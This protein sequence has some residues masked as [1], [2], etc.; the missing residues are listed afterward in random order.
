METERLSTVSALCWTPCHA[1]SRP[2]LRKKCGPTLP[3]CWCS[4]TCTSDPLK[5]GTK[6]KKRVVK[7]LSPVGTPVLLI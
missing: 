4:E 5:S 1:R 7:A 6:C 3:P 2:N